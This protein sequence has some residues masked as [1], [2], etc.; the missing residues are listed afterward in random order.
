MMDMDSKF[1]CALD[2]LLSS[3]SKTGGLIQMRELWNAA[4]TAC[5]K[6]VEE[7]AYANEKNAKEENFY[8]R[9]YAISKNITDHLAN[10]IREMLAP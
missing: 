6:S 7:T 5:L 3:A 10:K 4:I 2:E 1:A 8:P 9:G